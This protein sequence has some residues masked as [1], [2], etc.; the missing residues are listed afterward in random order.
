MYRGENEPWGAK[1]RLGGE[2]DRADGFAVV[3]P[4]LMTM[5]TVLPVLAFLLALSA[6]A[7]VASPARAMYCGTRLVSRG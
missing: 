5:R 1:D 6:T 7:L 2:K 3:H 4:A